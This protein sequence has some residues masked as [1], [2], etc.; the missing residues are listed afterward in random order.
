MA[1]IGV[2]HLVYSPISILGAGVRPTY[3]VGK[4][5]SQLTKVDYE[6]SVVDGTFYAD[7]VLAEE[8]HYVS[9]GTIK[10][11][12]ADVSIDDQKGIFGNTTDT[13]STVKELYKGS[14]DTAPYVGVGYI[15]PKKKNGNKVYEARFLLKVMFKEPSH[16]AETKGESISF[17]GMELE[18]SFSPVEGFEHDRYIEIAEF[19]TEA[20]AITW[21]N[22]KAHVSTS[23]ASSSSSSSSSSSGSSGS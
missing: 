13:V 7:D 17:Q 3:G 11:G 4:V 15:V 2:K 18:G 14:G 23:V 22:G 16:S 9:G 20:A 8:E 12:I 19:T 1:V 21:I 5:L 10:I 6:P